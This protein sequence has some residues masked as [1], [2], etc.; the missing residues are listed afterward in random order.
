MNFKTSHHE[1]FLGNI[2]Q[3][4]HLFCTDQKRKRAKIEKTEIDQSWTNRKLRQ[5]KTEQ[6]HCCFKKE[7]IEFNPWTRNNMATIDDKKV[8][9]WHFNGTL[10][11]TDKCLNK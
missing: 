7:P 9:I 3:Q 6:E 11:T 5:Q 4:L 10:I 2:F 8:T 1:L